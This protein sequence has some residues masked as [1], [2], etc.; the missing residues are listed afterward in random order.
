MKRSIVLF[1]LITLFL[2]LGC[3]SIY[4]VDYEPRIGIYALS[5]EVISGYHFYASQGLYGTYSNE[6]DI[7]ICISDSKA[8]LWRRS[9]KGLRISVFTSSGEEETFDLGDTTLIHFSYGGN[10]EPYHFYK[11]IFPVITSDPTP[12]NEI[13]EINSDVDTIYFQYKTATIPSIVITD[14]LIKN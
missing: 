3:T 1:L 5:P 12:D 8:W 7:Q 9:G 11:R 4:E 2:L 10:T 6:Q 13:L 14:T